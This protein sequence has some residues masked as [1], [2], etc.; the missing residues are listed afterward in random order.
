MVGQ[1]RKI[2]SGLGGLDAEKVTKV[3]INLEERVTALE[4][5]LKERNGKT[6]SK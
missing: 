2:I 4:A 5:T 6:K 3:L 1:A